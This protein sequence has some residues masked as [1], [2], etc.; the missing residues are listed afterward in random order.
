[1][2]LMGQVAEHWLDM[3]LTEKGKALLREIQPDAEQLPDAAWPAYAKGAFAEELCQIDLDAALKLTKG[4][5]DAREFDRHHGNIAHEL[6]GKDPAAAERVLGMVKD[7]Y[8]HDAVRGSCRVPDGPGRPRP[9]AAAGRHDGRPRDA[10]VRPRDGRA[11]T[12]GGEEDGRRDRALTRG[13]GHPRDRRR[14]RR[15]A[16]AEPVRPRQHVRGACVAVAERID[17]DLVPETFWRALSLRYPRRTDG[18]PR[19]ERRLRPAVGAPAGALRPRRGPRAGGA[20]RRPGG[21]G[22][23]AVGATAGSPS[24]PPP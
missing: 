1:M 23:G 16:H 10:R 6:A 17:P 14:I 20:A 21:V 19:P 18:G 2:L 11:R 4:L 8:Q 13:D 5:S 7:P 24:R 15:V 3:G 12:G 22:G 9:G